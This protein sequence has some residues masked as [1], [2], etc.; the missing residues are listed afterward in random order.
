MGIIE[1]F[2]KAENW[3]SLLTLTGMEIILGVDNVIFISLVTSRLELKEQPKARAI[4]LS[5]ALI[6]RISLLAFISYLASMTSTILSVASFNFS[7]R[8]LIM[9]GGGIFLIYKT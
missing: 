2:S 7:A 8:D 1:I 6:I 3:I 4:G 5:M 9:L